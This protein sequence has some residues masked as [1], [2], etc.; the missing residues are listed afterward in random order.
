M[1]FGRVGRPTYTLH[2]VSAATH[3]VLSKVRQWRIFILVI[4][5]T[6][7]FTRRLQNLLDAESYRLLQLALLHEPERGPVIPGTGGLRKI[8]WSGAG[9]GTRGGVRV[10]YLW[11]PDADVI[12]ML[13]I[14][15]KTEQD[16]LTAQQ[17]RIIRQLIERER[18]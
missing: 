7:V 6:S 12:L 15:A 3:S 11:R 1:V 2:S 17:K 16:D 13:M 5:E 10:I 4:K 18:R 14:Y 9:R 8:R